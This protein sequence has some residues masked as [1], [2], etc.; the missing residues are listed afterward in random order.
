MAAEDQK[1]SE[2]RLREYRES[3][4]ESLEQQLFSPAP[5]Y[6]DLEL[7]KLADALAMFVEQRGGDDPLV[8]E[9]LA[10]KSPRDR[11]AELIGG[12]TL[13]N[14]DT[15]RKIARRRNESD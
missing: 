8:A 11:A 13:G 7:V 4:R 14:V 5:I 1:P 9:V 3:A 12:T 6:N 10:G 2:E 15:R